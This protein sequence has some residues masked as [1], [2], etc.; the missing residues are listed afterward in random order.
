MREHMQTMQDSMQAMCEGL[1]AQMTPGG[2]HH[3]GITMGD[4]KDMKGADM[5]K[6]HDMMGKRMDMMLMMMEQMMQHHA[7]ESMPAK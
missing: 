1:G 3:A 6:H 4:H 5:M 2:G 7:A